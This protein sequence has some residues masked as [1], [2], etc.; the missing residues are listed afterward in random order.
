MGLLLRE[1]PSAMGDAR[2]EVGPV[3]KQWL[4]SFLGL[5]A[6]S[7]PREAEDRELLIDFLKWANV[8]GSTPEKLA[9]RYLQERRG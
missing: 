4:M 5:L 3:V 9:D 1:V 2:W 7:V 8:G 6:G